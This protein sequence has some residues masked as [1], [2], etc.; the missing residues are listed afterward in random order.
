MNAELE[1]EI[2]RREESVGIPA[3]R[4]QMRENAKVIRSTIPEIF[5]YKFQVGYID[6]II[7][8]FNV[9]GSGDTWE[10]AFDRADFKKRHMAD[11]KVVANA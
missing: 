1:A 11:G 10:E 9:E 4:E 7:G 6:N 2:K 3:L 5:A 8:A